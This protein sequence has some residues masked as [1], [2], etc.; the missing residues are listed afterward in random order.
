MNACSRLHKSLPV[1]AT[2]LISSCAT[3]SDHDVRV[4]VDGGTQRTSD[5][6][7]IATVESVAARRGVHVHWVHPPKPP[8]DD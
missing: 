6:Q 8:R 1:F 2:V 3:T 5:A 7:Y 4:A